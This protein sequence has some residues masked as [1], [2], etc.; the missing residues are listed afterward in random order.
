MSEQYEF[1]IPFRET[2]FATPCV[3]YALYEN[4][5]YCL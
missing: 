1:N 4:T 5:N 3:A 2:V